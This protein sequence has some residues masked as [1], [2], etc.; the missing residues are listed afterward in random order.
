MRFGLPL[1]ILFLANSAARAVV[2]ADPATATLYSVHF[3][4][5]KEGWTVG[6][7]GVIRHTIDGGKTWE[8]QASGT[9][10]SLRSVYFFDDSVG[11]VVGRDEKPFGGGSVGV[12]LYTRDGGLRWQQ[13]LNNALPGL[14]FV[15]FTDRDTGFLLGDGLD[16]FTSGMF[17]TT[18]GGKSWEP[19]KGMHAA[20]WADR[21]SVV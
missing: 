3:I 13:L 5:A 16:P 1:L 14:N 6:D 20:A 10:A 21:K 19:V 18:D 11:W 4:D 17:R 9:K 7:D 8:V 2:L 12:V 15:R